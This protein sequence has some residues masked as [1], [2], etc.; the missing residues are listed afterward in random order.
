MRS[1]PRGFALAMTL[2]IIALV[3]IVT[4]TAINVSQL[5]SRAS[6][7]D[8]TSTRA[9][10]AARAGLNWACTNI[11]TNYGWTGASGLTVGGVAGQETFNV[12]V[13]N[14][15]WNGSVTNNTNN[16]WRITSVGSFGGAQ[17]T[18]IG[19][20]QVEPFSIYAYFTDQERTSSGSMIRFA[21]GD[22]LTG[23][24]HTN[25]YFTFGGVTNFTDR[26]TSH[27]NQNAANGPVDSAYN[28]ASKSYPTAGS[29]MSGS[30]QWSATNNSAQFYHYD[31][32]LNLNTAGPT[33]HGGND[34][35]PF[36]SFQG[37]SAYVPLP[38][39]SPT[40]HDPLS[41]IKNNAS[42]SVMNS[43]G[44]TWTANSTTT[45]YKIV[46]DDDGSGSTTAANGGVTVQRTTDGG[47]NWSN[48]SESQAPPVYKVVFRD[49]PTPTATIY[50]KSSGANG[51][52]FV[53][54][55]SPVATDTQPGVTLYMDGM[56]LVSGTVKGRV[57]LG[58]QY[59]MHIVG[60]LVHSDS[61]RDVLGIV[62]GGNIMVEQHTADGSDREID[63]IMMTPRGSFQVRRYT[64]ALGSGPTPRLRITGGLIQDTRGAVGQ[65][66]SPIRGFLKDYKYDNKLRST[67]PLNFP[68]T[69]KIVL[70]AIRDLGALGSQ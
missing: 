16:R 68:T 23:A 38:G 37:G 54:Q 6:Q 55:G 27:N 42:T 48:V 47:S 3:A 57:T 11:Q 29:E 52:T 31:N 43:T 58:S 36:F 1:E 12:T 61:S 62:S 59:D 53:Q 24:V 67:P 70:T 2:V 9:L 30:Y 22:I 44:H 35:S 20:A 33:A 66:G 65:S 10:Y 4:F 21:Q 26:V 19:F 32:G 5:D 64:Q 40:P 50:K 14:A 15:T 39:T 56:T 8:Y 34:T 41:T 69:G 51:T 25:G 17:R 49:N 7:A 13:V 46:Y 63:A 28:A 18:L 60:N 45:K